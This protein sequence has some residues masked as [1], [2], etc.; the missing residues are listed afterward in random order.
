M[1]KTSFTF[2]LTP[3][4]Q[5]AAQQLLRSGNYPPVAVPHSIVG[6]EGPN[7]RITLFKSGKLL[8]QGQGAEDW[9]LFVLEPQVIGQAKVGYEDILNPTLATPHCGVDESGKGDFFGPL[10]IAAAYVDEELL[11]R[12]Q[13]LNVRDSKTITSDA[14]AESMARELRH[15]LGR[16]FAVVTIGPEAYNRLYAQMGNVNRILA[17][18]HARAIENILEAVPGCPRAVSDQFG[19]TRQIE[20]ALLKKGRRIKLEQRPKAESD[21]AVAAA[22]ILARAG[23]L[24]A[25]RKLREDFAG[26][27]FPKGASPAVKTEA[28]KLIAA[29]GPEIL[30]RT[31]KCHFRTADE[32]LATAGHARAVLGPLGAAKSKTPSGSF[33]RRPARPAAEDGGEPGAGPA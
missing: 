20:Q 8:V 19:P 29:H 28:G 11:P 1:K 26:C 9:V 27:T 33:H 31:A 4:Q 12:F 18:G 14:K 5:A 3:A 21:P 6:V 25:L 15:L 16:R 7:C 32:V 10:V 30:V 24:Q 23:F 22:S 2:P 17:W 13:T